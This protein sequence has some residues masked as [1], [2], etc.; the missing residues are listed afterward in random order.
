MVG[1]SRKARLQGGA[2]K[3]Q[4]A[5]QGTPEQAGEVAAATRD[6]VQMQV[7][8]VLV[9][10][11]AVVDQQVDPL[12]AIAGPTQR[13]AHLVG[14]GQQAFAGGGGE[15][16]EVGRVLAGDYQHMGRT[17]RVDVQQHQEVLVFMQQVG[18]QLAGGDGAEH[19]VHGHSLAV[20]GSC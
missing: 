4:E 13:L 1:F 10:S 9:G 2:T 16:G 14:A 8:Y 15:I 11:R 3:G 18:R 12:A 7:R 6:Q 20:K 5:G 17:Q 19:A